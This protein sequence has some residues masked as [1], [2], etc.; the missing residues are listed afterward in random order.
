MRAKLGQQSVHAA[1]DFGCCDFELGHPSLDGR[2][3]PVRVASG[4]LECDIAP[5]SPDS[6]RDGSGDLETLD[7]HPTVIVDDILVAVGTFGNVDV[8]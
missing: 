5:L 2:L 7:K 6:S 1:I 8:L 4:Q 3:A